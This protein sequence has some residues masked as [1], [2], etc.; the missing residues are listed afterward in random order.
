MT[1]PNEDEEQWFQIADMFADNARVKLTL[2][3]SWQ[4]VGTLRNWPGCAGA[5]GNYSA[6]LRHSSTWRCMIP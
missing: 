3:Q 2:S 6:S 4:S 5:H 1:Y